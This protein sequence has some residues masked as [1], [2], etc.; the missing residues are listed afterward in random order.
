MLFEACADFTPRFTYIGKVTVFAWNF[1]YAI[2]LIHRI[3]LVFWMD[4]DFPEG[5]MRFHCGFTRQSRKQSLGE[6]S[7]SAIAD[8]AVQFN[9]VINWEDAKVLQMESNSDARFIR[10]SLWIR[11][12]NT[13]TMNRDEGAHYLSH[14]YDPLLLMTSSK[15]L[16]H[17]GSNSGSKTRK[18]DHSY[19]VC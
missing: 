4:K 12:R 11:K 15:D 7:K 14:I 2:S 8:H 10:E 1:I 19:E 18:K 13:K 3:N 6:Q 16:R 17:T 9:H 5:S